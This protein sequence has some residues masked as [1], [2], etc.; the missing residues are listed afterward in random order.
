MA[1][2]NSDNQK[3]NEEVR[4]SISEYEGILGELAELKKL[5]QNKQPIHPVAEKWLTE[6]QTQNILGKKTTSLWA[7]RRKGKLKFSKIGGKI[8]YCAKS[9]E[10]LLERNAE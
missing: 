5:V 2:D 10:R 1:T 8:F 9:I 7:L 4:I 6:L 3:K